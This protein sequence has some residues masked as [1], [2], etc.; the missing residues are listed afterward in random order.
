MPS[1]H[2]LSNISDS[3]F[4]DLF[5]TGGEKPIEI[6]NT[7][8]SSSE[9]D[10]DL[11]NNSTTPTTTVASTTTTQSSTTDTTTI[12]D[13]DLF[14]ENGK[15]KNP[16]PNEFSDISG[17]FEDRLKT[18]K[19]IAISE[20]NENGE[21]VPFIPKTPEDFDEVIELQVNHR[22]EKAKKDLDQT[23][24][25]EKSIPW[26]IVAQYAEKVS[27]P[28]DILPFLQG[29]KNI[30]T[31]S[32][33][34]ETQIEGAEEIVRL[35]LESTGQPK[36][37]IDTQIEALKTTSKLLD[38]AKDLKPTMVQ[39]EQQKLASL[40]KQ[41]ENELR[42][43][44]NMVL[45]IENTA[46][47]IINSPLGKEKLKQEEKAAIY[48]LI[49]IPN[50]DTKG[51]G[52]FDKIDELYE[53]RD[54]EKLRKIAL[55]LNNEESFTKYISAGALEKNAAEFQRKLRITSEHG[56]GKESNEG[57]NPRVT[58]Q[59]DNYRTPRFGRE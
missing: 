57:P 3:Q 30:Q 32:S 18:G 55:L 24:Y 47:K 11:F 8:F 21:Q 27:N 20:E 36:S 13:V 17:Y 41:K 56:K 59:R 4:A 54:F 28:A 48:E 7:L 42:D 23:W 19:F 39:M 9:T 34:D 51:Y 1:Q 50:P 22:L 16:K 44:Q 2:E 6:T 35:Q 43:Y 14:D 37:L 58:I 25:A 12:G 45:D 5:S 15:A 38:A 10:A 29:I 33:I 40:N 31:V 49:A 26:Q 53:K 52:I 46:I